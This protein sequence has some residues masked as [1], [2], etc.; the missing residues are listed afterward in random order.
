[1]CDDMSLA[2]S[3]IIMIIIITLFKISFAYFK[4]LLGYLLWFQRYTS[5]CSKIDDVTNCTNK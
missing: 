1:M 3:I 4:D 5:L 2:L